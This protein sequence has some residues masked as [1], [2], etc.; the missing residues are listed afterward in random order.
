MIIVG[1][2]NKDDSAIVMD[3][4][5]FLRKRCRNPH[6]NNEL[7]EIITMVK[8]GKVLKEKYGIVKSLN[9]FRAT[10]SQQRQMEDLLVQ[11]TRRAEGKR[12]KLNGKDWFEVLQDL[13]ELR[14]AFPIVPLHHCIEVLCESL[15]CSEETEN[16]KLVEEIFDY[17]PADALFKGKSSMLYTLSV[18]KIGTIP[19]ESKI[20]VVI[21]ACEYYLDSSKDVDDANLGLAKHCLTLVE[22]STEKIEDNGNT[23]PLKK[24]YCLLSALDMLAEFGV[25][26]L[27]IVLR[28]ASLN[29]NSLHQVIE[30][31]LDV[32][33]TNYKNMR[34]ILKLVRL[35]N[36]ARNDKEDSDKSL[37][38]KQ[39]EF[40]EDYLQK[41]E[42]ENSVLG[43]IAESA[44]KAGDYEACYG[45]CELLMESVPAGNE[46]AVKACLALA[47]CD[48]YM[49]F[50]GAKSRMS[51]FCVNYC[52]DEEIEDM[53]S[54]RIE[55][56]ETMI[57][58]KPIP[59]KVSYLRIYQIELLHNFCLERFHLVFSED[60]L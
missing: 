31:I 51:S 35:L 57:L 14:L 60:I 3:L 37:P 24:Y 43:R 26:I 42:N 41:K 11:V 55:L 10:K 15:L 58:N 17:S 5:S 54:H 45:I 1:D 25:S 34:K 59:D 4:A 32:D 9:Y 19:H 22:K 33:S 7:A 16:I 49:D 28:N 44:M 40:S 8:A 39:A 6:V 23:K 48:E 13:F 30:K 29:R 27:P 2:E 50:Q 20:N 52:S 36:D 53:L 18:Y 38:S 56:E 21:K 46:Y 47:N 12:P